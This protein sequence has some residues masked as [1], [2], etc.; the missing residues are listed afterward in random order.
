[1]ETGKCQAM[2]SGCKEK[3]FDVYSAK[4]TSKRY[5]FLYITVYSYLDSM[6]FFKT[7][8]PCR[9]VPKVALNFSCYQYG[10]R[11]GTDKYI[12]P[13]SVVKMVMF[14]IL[15]VGLSLFHSPIAHRIS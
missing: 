12:K 4:E 10:D 7:S 1:M 3:K 15:S 6:Q 9:L 11:I 8:Y 13:R 5:P 2:P 14:V